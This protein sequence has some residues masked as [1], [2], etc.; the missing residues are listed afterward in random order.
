MNCPR[1][2][3]VPHPVTPLVT[4]GSYSSPHT[5]RPELGVSRAPPLPSYSC[6]SAEQRA[7]CLPVPGAPV[8]SLPAGSLF[9]CA[10]LQSTVKRTETQQLPKT[11]RLDQSVS[12]QAFLICVSYLLFRKELGGSL[13][14]HAL[15]R[16]PT[17]LLKPPPTPAQGLS[18]RRDVAKIGV[19]SPFSFS[20]Y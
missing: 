6:L 18:S 13:S 7:A 12:K 10:H 20:K 19:S 9:S 1:E 14:G 3:G 16:E 11:V 17:K 4:G 2:H 8:P 15:Q 5:E